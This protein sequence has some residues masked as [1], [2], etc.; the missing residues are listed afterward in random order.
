MAEWA[1]PCRP[2]DRSPAPTW[3]V[4]AARLA[5]LPAHVTVLR[6]QEGE[7]WVCAVVDRSA[8]VAVDGQLLREAYASDAED[9][10]ACRERAEPPAPPARTEAASAAGSGR[11]VQAAALSVQG[12]R[13]VVVLVGMDL[14]DA[15]GEAALAIETLEARF[16][17]VPVVLMAQ[18]EDGSPRYFGPAPL[19]VLLEGLP[20]E[21][22]P[23]KT[24][25]L[26]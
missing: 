3:F 7:D 4:A 5:D 15:A 10:P 22:M 21:K 6:V 16:G 23:W 8:P 20:L 12:E 25:A 19:L 14:L 11:E 18:L 24:Y 9:C 17:G 13:M 2:C 1:Y 26:G